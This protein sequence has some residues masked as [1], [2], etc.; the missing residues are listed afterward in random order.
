MLRVGVTGKLCVKVNNRA[1]GGIATTL[2]AGVLPAFA[3]AR[4]HAYCVL[5]RKYFSRFVACGW[6]V[7]YAFSLFVFQVV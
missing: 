6:R 2:L 5:T 7:P 1:G 4:A 3:R